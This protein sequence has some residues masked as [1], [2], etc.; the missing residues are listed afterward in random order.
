MR[1][2]FSLDSVEEQLWK[3]VKLGYLGL[4]Y[5]HKQPELAE[6]FYN[7]V[8][9]WLFDR[10]YY[11]N[12]NIFVRPGLSTEYL[13]GDKPTYHSFLSDPRRAE[14]LCRGDITLFKF[15]IPFENLERDVKRLVE[16]IKLRSLTTIEFR[17]HFQLQVLS[18]PL[19]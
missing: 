13:E 9:T 6:T 10:R 17:Q 19:L 15:D 1:A 12:D 11:S 16:C 8:F 18:A 14:R 3:E 4:L 2:E 7:S 5:D